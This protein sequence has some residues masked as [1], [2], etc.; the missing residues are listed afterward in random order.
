MKKAL[1]IAGGLT[2]LSQ[3]A[4]ANDW[5]GFYAGVGVAHTT[6]SHSLTDIDYDWFGG[7]FT[8]STSSLTP[9]V[10]FGIN[11]SNENVVYGLE[12]DFRYA[13]MGTD[14]FYAQDDF[15]QDE[16]NHSYSLRARLGVTS[17][18]SL[19]F[20]TAGAAQMDVSHSWYEIAD[21]PDSW[22][23]KGNYKIGRAFGAGIEHKVGD[24]L[25]VRAEYQ[26]VALPG[27]TRLNNSQG[28]RFEFEDEYEAVSVGATFHF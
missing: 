22:P 15:R 21:L 3:G 10:Y 7:T 4:L 27:D 25:S 2:L 8:E 13:E 16:F 23:K 11:F 14:T 5:D 24:N 20:F 19:L 26:N 17:G 9:S 1:I 12:A 28:N 18:S 6:Y